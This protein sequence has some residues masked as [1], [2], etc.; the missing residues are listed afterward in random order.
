MVRKGAYYSRGLTLIELLITLV[1]LAILISTVRASY[2]ALFA[3]QAL[4]QRAEKLHRILSLTSSQAIRKNSVV[5]AHFCP[6][7]VSGAWQVIT[8]DVDNCDCININ[9][10]LF[11]GLL[12]SEQI[13]DGN[14]V[15]TSAADINFSSQ[16][17][18]YGAMRFNVNTGSVKF[19]TPDGAQLKVI[20]ST[21][22]LRICSPNEALLGYK[23]C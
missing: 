11:D 10:C 15:S 23:K 2:Y 6:M 18:S 17:A 4:I 3:H 5:Y 13:S 22:R 19:S 16:Q 14:K 1:I 20:Q 21:M 9:S 12:V 7:Q 8:T